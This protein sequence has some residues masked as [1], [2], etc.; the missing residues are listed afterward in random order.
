MHRFVWNLRWT[1]SGGPTDVDD[2]FYYHVPGGPK[3]APGMYELRLTVDGK[4][5]TQT[6]KLVMDPRSEATP[7]ILEQQLQL[8]RHIFADTMELRRTLAEIASVQKQL[9]DRTR[10]LLQSK[11]KRNVEALLAKLKEAQSS[12]EKILENKQSGAQDNSGLQ[13]ANAALA[14]ALRAVETSDRPIPSQVIAVYKEAGGRA[15]AGMAAWKRFAQINLVELNR[16]LQES[17]LAPVNIPEIE[18]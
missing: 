10:G 5:Q 16:Q 13:D 6:L 14:W 7:E 2:E 11:S 17:Y 9:I 12:S 1:S 18:E 4:T 8:G 15:R 3:A